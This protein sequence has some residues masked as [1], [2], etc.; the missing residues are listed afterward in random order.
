MSDEP[1]Y[2]LTQARMMLAAKMRDANIDEQ[3][4][5]D[6]LEGDSEELSRKIED[7]GYVIINEEAGA[8]LIK[9]EIERLE[10]RYAAKVKRIDYARDFLK[11][12]MIACEFKNVDCNIFN[13]AVQDNPSACEIVDVNLVPAEYM[14][15][16]PTPPT[17]PAVPDKAAI[18][19]VLRKGGEVAG[20][21]ETVATKLVIK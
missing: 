5:L 9:N 16:P 7:W 11:K 3:T 18:L 12:S 6:T 19:K 21:K 13:I 15:Q 10:A 1:L 8:A 17:P 4:V 20:C 2:K 14:R